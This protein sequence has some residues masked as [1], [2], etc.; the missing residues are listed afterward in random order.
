MLGRIDVS[1][2]NNRYIQ[3]LRLILETS[4]IISSEALTPT[5]KEICG[6]VVSSRF[7]CYDWELLVTRVSQIQSF[8]LG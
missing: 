3:W 8:I 5:Q 1:S 4:D 7:M 6:S 2:M